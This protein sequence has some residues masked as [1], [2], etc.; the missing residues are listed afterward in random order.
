MVNVKELAKQEE[1]MTG[2]TFA[3]SGC[4]AVYGLRLL[5]MALGKKMIIVNSAGCMTLTATYPYTCYKTP[6]LFNAIENAAPTATGIEKGLKAQG[7]DDVTV[8]CYA[9]DGASYEI[10][11]GPLSGAA[12]RNDNI[13]YICY[14]N[15]NYANTGH[16]V[17]PATQ[18]FARTKTTPIGTKNKLGNIIPRKNLAKLMALHDIPYAA[19]ASTG[20]QHDFID[21]VRKASKIKGFK[22]IDLLCA[23]EP[24][25][26]VKTH[27]MNKVSKLMVDTGM[28]PMYEIE[29]KKVTINMKPLMTPVETAL[30]M[31]GRYA[32]LTPELIQKVQKLVNKEWEMIN[33][34]KFWEAD[35]Y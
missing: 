11:F 33:A 1:H 14:N 23:C 15:F 6:W 17:S 19:T 26:L 31:Q 28:W 4:Q 7:K 29:K 21:K 20:Y 25:W 5:Q 2:G 12:Y 8:V 35:E 18:E 16:Q 9:G 22:F 3:C 10:G 34:G 32:H 27:E 13:L 30:K 24:G